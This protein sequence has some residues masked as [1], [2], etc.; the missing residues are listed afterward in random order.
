MENLEADLRSLFANAQK[1]E[2]AA[3]LPHRIRIGGYLIEA[4]PQLSRK[5]FFA[6]ARRNFGFG[7]RM[8]LEY[9]LTAARNGAETKF[10]TPKT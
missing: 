4:E 7:Q 1:E 6:W 8:A 10:V 5:E 9:M 3:T 2:D